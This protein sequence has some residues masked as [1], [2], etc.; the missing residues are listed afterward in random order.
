MKR[1]SSLEVSKT[2]ANP[3]LPECSQK[4]HAIAKHA[5]GNRVWLATAL[6]QQIYKYFVSVAVRAR[7]PRHETKT[8]NSESFHLII[9]EANRK[10]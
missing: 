4:P 10:Q 9:T 7:V 2:R 6:L 1:L 3:L 5:Q 8:E